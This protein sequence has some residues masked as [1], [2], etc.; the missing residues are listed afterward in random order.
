MP[1]GGMS[2]MR[3]AIVTETFVPKVDG[4]VTR[5]TRTIEH[6]VQAGHEVLVVAPEGGI[7][8]YAGARVLG[9]PSPP[10]PLY[11]E[12][13]IVLPRP[14]V[15][16]IGDTAQYIRFATNAVRHSQRLLRVLLRAI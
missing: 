12:N 11:S 10:L 15:C 5:L 9:I 4:I 7:K 14:H 13:R 6:L 3:I 1:A 8:D 2:G 16:Q